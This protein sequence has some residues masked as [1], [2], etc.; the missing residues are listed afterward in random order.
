MLQQ[1]KDKYS[2]SIAEF[3]DPLNEFEY[4]IPHGRYN[5]AAQLCIKGDHVGKLMDDEYK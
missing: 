2:M 4:H 5:V 1:K 3:I